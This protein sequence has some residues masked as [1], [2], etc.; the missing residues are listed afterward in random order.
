MCAGLASSV[1]AV[2]G[3]GTRC[4]LVL[5]GPD[6][7]HAVEVGP[8]NVTSDFDAAIAEIEAGLGALANAAGTDAAALRDLPAFVGL[9]GVVDAA[10]AARVAAALPLRRARVEDDRPSA[11][12]GA[13]GARDGAIGHFGTGS[14]FALQAGGQVRLAGSWGSRLGDE[15]SAFWV[16]R[17]A[18]SATLEAVDR[19]IEPTGLTEALLAR[20]GS[21]GGIVAEAATAAPGQIG[22]LAVLVTA[23]AVEDDA[24]AL[25]ILRAGG[26][27][28]ARVTAQMGW[29]PGMAFCLTGGL[30][31]S[32]RPYLPAPLE[33]ALIAP[34]AAPIEGAVALARAFAA[35][36]A[37]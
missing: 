14:F 20:F 7:R 24:V 34:D 2:D 6:G 5:D 8:A 36:T 10:M 29:Q 30:G 9:A 16:A 25:R 12:R 23:A 19:L 31:P 1:I 28:I 21:P 15:G 22:A 13:L 18:L 32:Y 35:E 11:L 33:R 27:H 4:R 3:G 26:D 37:P 17:A